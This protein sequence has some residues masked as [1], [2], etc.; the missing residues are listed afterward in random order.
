MNDIFSAL[1]RTV[2]F[3]WSRQAM[4]PEAINK[5]RNAKVVIVSKN[6]GNTIRPNF[7]LNIIYVTERSRNLLRDVRLRGGLKV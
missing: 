2:T 7:L 6:I 5:V 4:E 1:P 3:Q